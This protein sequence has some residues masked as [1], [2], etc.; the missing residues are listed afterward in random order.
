M[1]TTP[2]RTKATGF[3]AY[4]YHQLVGLL[5]RLPQSSILTVQPRTAKTWKWELAFMT[6]LL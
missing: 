1:S 3:H 2:L 5:P 4:R 6:D